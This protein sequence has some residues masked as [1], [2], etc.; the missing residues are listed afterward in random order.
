MDRQ[1]RSHTAE[2]QVVADAKARDVGEIVIVSPGKTFFMVGMVDALSFALLSA[3]G[4][5][6]RG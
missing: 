2:D 5:A 6:M 4:G 1:A 3:F